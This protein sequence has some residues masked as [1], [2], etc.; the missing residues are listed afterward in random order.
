VGAPRRE[1]V[2]GHTVDTGPASDYPIDLTS[3]DFGVLNFSGVGGGSILYNTQWPRMLPYDFRVR[4]VDG[5][6][7]RGRA[8]LCPSPGHQIWKKWAGTTDLALA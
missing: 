7:K 4:T 8:L 6:I 2:V 1:A 3:S 5:G